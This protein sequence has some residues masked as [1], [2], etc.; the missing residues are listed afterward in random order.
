M[1]RRRSGLERL[2]RGLYFAQR[3]IGDF[4]ALQRGP[5]VYA[6]RRIRRRL[7]RSFFQSLRSLGR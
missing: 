4:Q 2:R 1:A 6:K 5:G 7:T 3:D